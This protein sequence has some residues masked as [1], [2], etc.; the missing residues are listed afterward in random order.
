MSSFL[1]ADYVA[2]TQADSYITIYSN[3]TKAGRQDISQEPFHRWNF[4]LVLAPDAL[5]VEK[6]QTKVRIHRQT[7]GFATPFKITCPLFDGMA[8]QPSTKTFRCQT[9][10]DA[11]VGRLTIRQTAGTV[12]TTI[13]DGQ[14]LRPSTANKVYCVNEGAIITSLNSDVEIEIFPSL[15]AQINALTTIIMNEVEATVVYDAGNRQFHWVHESNLEG[16]YEP[17][18]NLIEVIA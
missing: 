6:L 12:P 13:E 9:K 7:R 5:G 17:V 3:V 16:I 14:W 4:T 8:E 1:G 2:G 18:L 15:Q 10:H 11:G